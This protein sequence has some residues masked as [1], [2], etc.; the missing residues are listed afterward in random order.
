MTRKIKVWTR[1]WISRRKSE[2]IYF[3]TFE[4]L[5]NFTVFDK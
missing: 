5:I 1:A 2:S 4:E 3:T